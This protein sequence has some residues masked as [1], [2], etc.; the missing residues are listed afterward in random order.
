MLKGILTHQNGA[1]SGLTKLKTFSALSRE[2]IWEGKFE[3][4]YQFTGQINPQMGQDPGWRG[5]GCGGH[6]GQ[7]GYRC[8]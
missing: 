7:D 1:G 2:E 5:L 3:D 8:M 6:S 4:G